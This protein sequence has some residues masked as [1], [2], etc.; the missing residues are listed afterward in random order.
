MAGE[1][2]I[3][4]EEK[5]IA[6]VIAAKETGFML[7]LML[8]VI[9]AIPESPLRKP[10]LKIDMICTLFATDI[11]TTTKGAMTEMLLKASSKKPNAPTVQ[12]MVNPTCDRM[13]API[14]N[15]LKQ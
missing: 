1:D 8:W 12:I 6:V 11:I 7:D 15:D 14:A 2:D 9:A 5:P 4:S 10:C 3:F 13:H